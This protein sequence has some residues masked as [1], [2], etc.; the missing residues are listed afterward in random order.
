[1]AEKASSQTVEVRRSSEDLEGKYLTFLLGAEEY[2]LEILKVQEIIKLMDITRLPQSLEFIR[3]VINLRGKV[4]PVVCLRRKFG[5]ETVDSTEK[6]CIIVVQAVRDGEPIT[7]GII[8]DEVSEVLDIPG[9]DIAP[10][11]ALGKAISGDFIL[12]MAKGEGTVKILMDID[13][14][15]SVDEMAAVS[16]AA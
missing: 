3:G 16:A 2:G 14:V 12:G 8:V 9:E 6:T 15:L 4:V 1:M 7:I 5:M 11:P 10:P 13:M